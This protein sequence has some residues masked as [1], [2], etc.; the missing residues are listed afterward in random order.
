[1]ARQ[2]VGSPESRCSILSSLSSDWDVDVLM[3]SVVIRVDSSMWWCALN[4][5]L[6]SNILLRWNVEDRCYLR[7]VPWWFIIYEGTRIVAEGCVGGGVCGAAVSRTV[8]ESTGKRTTGR[9]ELNALS[10]VHRVGI[11]R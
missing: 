5:V 10:R 2:R 8:R 11:W 6:V 4:S 3:V 9:T 1:M 7:N